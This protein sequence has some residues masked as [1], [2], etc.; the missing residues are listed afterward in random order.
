MKTYL[1]TRHFAR[2][3][4]GSVLL[5]VVAILA[6][7]GLLVTTLGFTSRVDYMAAQNWASSVQARMAVASELPAFEA[8]AAAGSLASLADAG[9]PA[10][11]VLTDPAPAAL[12]SARGASAVAAAA[13]LEP[14]AIRLK[15]DRSPRQVAI[16]TTL[17]EAPGPRLQSEKEAEA[18]A[19]D[20]DARPPVRLDRTAALAELR[21]LDT[22]AKLNINAIVPSAVVTDRAVGNMGKPALPGA[23][24][25]AGQVTEEVLARLIEGV[26]EANGIAGAAARPLAHAIAI[27]R[28]GPDGKPGLAGVDDNA[29]GADESLSRLREAANRELTTGTPY[30]PAPIGILR[31]GLDN[32][33]DGFVD[34][35]GETIARDGIDNDLDGQIDEPGE[36]IDDPAES[37]ADIRLPAVGDDQPYAVL[38]E[39]LTIPGMTEELF[40]ALE[41]HLTIFSVS[42]AAFELPEKE[43]DVALGWPQLDPN[44][45]PAPQIFESLRRR[46]PGASDRQLAQFA[47]NVVDR[48]DADSIPTR[49]AIDGGPEILGFELTPFINEVCASPRGLAIRNRPDNDGQF[50]EIVNPYKDKSFSLDGWF[51]RGG[52]TEIALNGQLP[53]GGFLVL[54]D[55]FNNENDSNR[56]DNPGSFFSRFQMVSGGAGSRVVEAPGLELGQGGRLELVDAEQRL[57]DVFEYAVKQGEATVAGFQR[58]D[59][60][61]RVTVSGAPTPLQ[62]NRGGTRTDD[63]ASAA[64]LAISTMEQSWNK[65]FASALDLMLVSTA[66]SEPGASAD[67]EGSYPWQLPALDAGEKTTNLDVRLVDCFRPGTRL[68]WGD[69]TDRARAGT[70]WTDRELTADRLR[71]LAEQ[72][73]ELPEAPLADAVF[74]LLNLN[75]ASLGVVA[76]LPGVDEDF[77]AR[78]HYAR[79][80]MRRYDE[81]ERLGKTGREL[82]PA[83]KTYWRPVSPE[84]DPCWATLSEFLLDD[85]LWRDTTLYERLNQ[86]YAFT[87]LVGFHS[88]SMQT[89]ATNLVS[90][91]ETARNSR[92]PA[93]GRAELILAADRGAVETVAFR[94]VEPAADSA[95]L[96][97][98]LRYAIPLSEAA[99]HF[100]VEQRAAGQAERQAAA[101]GEA[102]AR[103]SSR[104]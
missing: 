44:A 30:D 76:A 56:R 9:G 85:V 57:I 19:R 66:W 50:V 102:D 61:L 98:D 71:E 1:H 37:V 33:R 65:P 13:P 82:R 55:D 20:S 103:N 41:P 51:L 26:I 25:P 34:N 39:L 28:Y 75:T 35:P 6:V 59:P 78:F 93:M 92:R 52:G 101:A 40:A 99:V 94:F 8:T 54:T 38:S 32:D 97:A 43:G 91:T 90:P 24:L 74:G 49:L 62:P 2:A 12:A 3:R 15:L 14:V 67:G 53:P 96:D 95:T 68:P 58:L 64:A 73:I 11:E 80:V 81:K 36:A 48:R 100:T 88:L 72:P 46:F 87:G 10:V 21:V 22:A 27:R 5:I 79:D 104:Q 47:A 18:A 63:A 16:A 69:A 42:L 45:A 77:V 84:V 83:D 29:N 70:A 4:T 89:V 86:S 23:A 7:L 60:R 17:D 31:D